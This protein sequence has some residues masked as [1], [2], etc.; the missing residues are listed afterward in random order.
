MKTSIKSL[1]VL[2][3]S[4]L[5]ISNYLSEGA[6]WPQWRGQ[7]RDGK[8]SDTQLLGAW[9][10]TGPKLDYKA[11]G[12]GKAYA[13]ISISGNRLYT[14]GDIDG[15]SR[16]L[17]LN[18]GDGK[19][20]W[21]AKVGAPGAPGWGGFAG[22][23]C[24]PTVDGNFL[25]TVDQWGELV[26]LNAA[27]GKE[28]WR[29]NFEKDFGSKRPEWGFAESPLVDGDKVIVTPGGPKGAI[30]A[31]NKKTGEV[32][33]RT[34]DFTDEAQYSSLIAAK[35]DGVEQYIQLTMKSV[36]GVSPKD[37]AI[38]WKTARKGNVAV[39]PTP[40]VD[41]NNIYVTSGYDMGCNLFKVTSS[42]GKFAV[43]QVY[44]N[45]NMM[46]HHGGVVK[47]GDYLYGHSD[48][49]GLVCQNFKTGEIVWAEKEKVKK[50]CVSFADGKL[51]FREEES[52]AMILIEA[53]PKAYVEKGRFNQP[54]R[55]SEKAWPHPSIANGKLYIRDQDSLFCY[56]LNA[57]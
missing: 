26:C 22:P 1:G 14:M 6:D 20:L 18:A 55:A 56:D 3:L 48:N 25:F 32:V 37:G 21:T 45:K 41:G 24:M 47:D 46:N 52:G 13:G 27:D 11:T 50:G 53:T 8:S 39:I 57:K 38:L 54:D 43:E 16:V 33:W 10:E 51:I 4:A 19:I 15:A 7:H 9:P 44:I 34:A 49:K 17:A 5:L 30:V 29:K 12:L 31:L 35:I 23:R 28:V 36:V 40:I 2:S 42:G